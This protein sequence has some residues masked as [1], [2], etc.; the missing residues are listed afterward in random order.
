MN[1][2]NCTIS[3]QDFKIEASISGIILQ[4]NQIELRSSFWIEYYD[5]LI[6]NIPYETSLGMA[7]VRIYDSLGQ[8]VQEFNN[9]QPNILGK[10]FLH[11]ITS[12][13]TFGEYFVRFRV[14]FLNE[15]YPW[16]WDDNHYLDRDLTFTINKPQGKYV[17]LF[18]EELG[19]IIE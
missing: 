8:L 7:R 11:T 1:L 10:Y 3:E 6:D 2:N 16:G 5:G 9:L 12:N 13:L 18:D 17:K 14:Y 15:Q 19:I 4:N